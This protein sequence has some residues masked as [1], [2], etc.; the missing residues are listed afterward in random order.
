M[1]PRPTG[2]TQVLVA[3]AGPVGL[4][5]AHELARRGLRVRLVDAASGPSR[6]SRAVATHPRTLETYDQMG[7]VGDILGR[8]R[9]NRAFTM[10]AKGR[11]LVR[12][13]ADYST[14]PTSYPYT[15]VIGQTETEAVLRDAVA[16]LGVEVEWGVRLA[17]F[18]QDADGVRARLTGED[19]TEE[20]VDADWLVG[21]DGGHS[22]VRKLLGLELT[23][24]TSDTWMLADAPVATDLPPD[25]IYWAHT[26]TQAL[27]MV[28]YAREGHWRLLDTAPVSRAADP[29]P[30]QERLT[31]KL[32]AGLGRDVRVGEPEWT[33]TF[34]FQQRM[35]ERMHEGRVFVA[36]DAAHVHSPAS[37]QGMNTGI[38]EA[39]N[40]AWKL[41][42]VEQ[43]HAGRELLGTYDEERLPIGRALLGSTRAA[44]FLVQ[45]KNLLASVALPVVFTVV[46]NVPPLRRAIQRKVLGGMSGLRIGYGDS[47]LTTV[48]SYR[49]IAGS[50]S[51][52]VSGVEPTPAPAPGERVT[53]AHV[54]DGDD[55]G[56]AG[57]RA[58]LRDPR[59]SLLLAAGG[60]GP[61]DVPVGVAITAAAQYGEWLS[62]RTVGGAGP[63][64]PAPLADP[65]GRLREALGLA[66]GGWLLVRP[67]G[68]V[69]ARGTA[70]TRVALGRA[71][72]PL[73]PAAPLADAARPEPG[74]VVGARARR[75][76][77][78]GS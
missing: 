2:R 51:A 78:H 3:G 74:L 46:R 13:D 38:Q 70:L 45:L 42:M 1:T 23:G 43:G 8:G 39:Y 31:Q 26:G 48:E 33:S 14:M 64:G 56:C 50:G 76:N 29:R 58:E 28:P 15:L 32:S 40:L 67:D 47:S 24:R 6:T 72:A 44:T 10:Y 68:Y 17:G 49:L 63:D 19:G 30:A 18:E 75:L 5:A 59:W 37:G 7:V 41:A 65:D 34:T 36:G 71:L 22:T 35:V 21:C 69:A 73:R 61:G 60:T 20:H 53:H 54:H 11:R 52:V 16:R 9:R 57:L 12:L 27:M 66:P 55:T 4:T 62:V 25:T 77:Q